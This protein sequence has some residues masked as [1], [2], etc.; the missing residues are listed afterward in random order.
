MDVVADTGP[1][2]G[3]IVAAED[4]QTLAGHLAM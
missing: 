2:A 3:R 4:L 1:V